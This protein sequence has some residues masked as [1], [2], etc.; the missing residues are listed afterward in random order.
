MTQIQDM[1]PYVEFVKR[2]V[3]DRSQEV[4]RGAYG[5]RD[6]HIAKIT[7]PGQKDTVERLAEEWLADLWKQSRDGRIPTSWAEGFEKKFQAW[8]TGQEI[9]A[10]GTPIRGWALLSPAQQEIIVSKGIRSVEDLAACSEEAIRGIGMGA[11]EF[12]NKARAW[13]E[14]YKDK[15][16]VAAQV[17][18]LQRDNEALKETLAQLREQLDALTPKKEAPKGKL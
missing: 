8:Q 4:V 6:I 5:F 12:R 16:A 15:G 13:V 14:Q 11:V 9:P 18:T 17:A 2:A 10:D 3:E 7:R 1:P